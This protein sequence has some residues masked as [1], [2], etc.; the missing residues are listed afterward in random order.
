MKN[1]KPTHK[2]TQEQFSQVLVANDYN[3]AATAKDIK[4]RYHITY[5]RQAVRQRA[6]FYGHYNRYE[7]SDEYEGDL[8]ERLYAKAVYNSVNRTNH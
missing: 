6:L 8:S 5:T 7:A 3:Y 2:L 1:K 4:R